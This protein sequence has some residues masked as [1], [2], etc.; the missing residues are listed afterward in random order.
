MAIVYAVNKPHS[1]YNSRMPAA[2]ASQPRKEIVINLSWLIRHKILVLV[3]VA[4]TIFLVSLIAEVVHLTTRPEHSF[5][6]MLSN[7]LSTVSVTRKVTRKQNDS[8]LEQY[9]QLSF[10][11]EPRSRSVIVLKQAGKGGTS[12]EVKTETIGTTN[13]DYSRYVTIKT[14]QKNAAGKVPDFSGVEGLW[15]QAGKG[16]ENQF[17][18]QAALGLVPFANLTAEQRS[19]IIGD[20][21]KK[22][23]YDVNFSKAK[24]ETVDGKHVWSYPV[25]MNVAAYVTVLQQFG[26]ISGIPGLDKL[27]ATSYAQTPPAELTISVDKFSHQL[28]RVAY[29]DGS[30]SE[31]YG[32]Y[33]LSSQIELPEKTVPLADLQQMIQSVQ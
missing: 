3:I 11:G 27:D 18:Q 22:N 9:T 2:P 8:S 29:N 23:I 16:N 15:G 4:A 21:Y 7:N 17:L 25:R 24:A 32:S 13:N 5:K 33:G 31:D 26:K 14:N 1:C 19:K 10:L 30:Q 28:I 12:T 6:A 20:I